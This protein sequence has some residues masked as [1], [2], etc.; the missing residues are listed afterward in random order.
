[1]GRVA[2]DTN[3]EAGS[4]DQED[5]P[6]DRSGTGHSTAGR[7]RVGRPRLP[8]LPPPTGRPEAG[9]HLPERHRL[10]AVHHGGRNEAVDQ[11]SG[12]GPEQPGA[13]G[14]TRRTGI[15]ILDL[16]PAAAW[17]GR[18]LHG[19]AVG[20]PRRRQDAGTHRHRRRR[21][22]P[23]AVG[24]GRDRGRRISPSPPA[25]I[26]D[27]FAGRLDGDTGRAADGPATPRPVPHV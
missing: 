2:Y 6:H 4:N 12:R 27:H 7:A 21:Q 8:G 24:L 9:H 11:H 25:P 13:A 18:R 15:P 17:L 20:S 16:H 1:M 5:R 14:G 19:R 22:H 3:S 23:G 10:A 26:Q